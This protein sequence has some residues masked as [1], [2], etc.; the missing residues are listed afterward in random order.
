M[1]T[2]SIM[3]GLALT[4]VSMVVVFVVLG[5]IWGLV[6]LVSKF[7]KQQDPVTE[8]NDT[9][10]TTKHPVETHPHASK[11]LEANKKNQ[12]VAELMALVLASEDK[13]NKKF[14]II[15]SKRIK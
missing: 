4:V 6:E 2:I 7:I 11:N 15:E 9:N 10:T 12:Q 8:F 1:E 13:P 3:D 5:S 14:E